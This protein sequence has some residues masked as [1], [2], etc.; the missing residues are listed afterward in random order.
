MPPF[1]FLAESDAALLRVIP[2]EED[3]FFFRPPSIKTGY[4]W[5]PLLVLQISTWA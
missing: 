1:L 2:G 4:L 5:V 3:F